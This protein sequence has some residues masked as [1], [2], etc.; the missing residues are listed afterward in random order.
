MAAH[1]WNAHGASNQVQNRGF[2]CCMTAATRWIACA[3][4]HGAL[5]SPRP[6]AASKHHQQADT[7]FAPIA[8][9]RSRVPLA[10][11]KYVFTSCSSRDTRRSPPQTCLNP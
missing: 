1:L 3:R 5:R 8:E 10:T 7:G 9:R 2:S 4:P 11:L 6:A